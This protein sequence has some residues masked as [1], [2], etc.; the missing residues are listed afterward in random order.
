MNVRG[1][2]EPPSDTSGTSGGGSFPVACN[3]VRITNAAGGILECITFQEACTRGIVTDAAICT[4][5]VSN[6]N[7]LSGVAQVSGS[8]AATSALAQSS[9]F[10]ACV[11]CGGV[12]ALL[13]IADL[14]L[15][16]R[17]VFRR[18]KA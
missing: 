18:G 6:T 9:Q 12:I 10:G 15:G 14:M 16:T 7:Q 8:T 17:L 13:L 5:Q 1:G 4:L 3:Q 11:S 2:G